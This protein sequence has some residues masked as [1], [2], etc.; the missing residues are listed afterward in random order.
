[1]QDSPFRLPE[2]RRYVKEFQNFLD[3]LTRDFSKNCVDRLLHFLYNFLRR[4]VEVNQNVER[5]Y[6]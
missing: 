3:A 5:P 6:R 4:L 2:T 1:M